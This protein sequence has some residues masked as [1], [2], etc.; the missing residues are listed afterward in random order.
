MD[1]G[2]GHTVMFRVV[3][4]WGFQGEMGLSLGGG[5][6]FVTPTETKV[7]GDAFCFMVKTWATHKTTETVL[8]NG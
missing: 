3:R 4:G 1:L 7:H 6:G 5:G 2:V 8:N